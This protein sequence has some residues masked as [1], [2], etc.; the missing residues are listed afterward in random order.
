MIGHMATNLQKN[1][2]AAAFDVRGGAQY[3][4]LGETKFREKLRNGEIRSRRCG[5]RHIISRA[6]LDRWLAETETK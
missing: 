2:P 6:D 5:R 1:I 3:V 4:G